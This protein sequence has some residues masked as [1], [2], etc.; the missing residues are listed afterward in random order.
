MWRQPAA[1]QPTAHARGGVSACTTARRRFPFSYAGRA[2]LS[3]YRRRCLSC[4]QHRRHRPPP[5]W[6]SQPRIVLFFVLFLAAGLMVKGGGAVRH[7]IGRHGTGHRARSQHSPP[8]PPSDCAHIDHRRAPHP[9]SVHCK[10]A[11][12]HARERAFEYATA[13]PSPLSHV[14]ASGRTRPSR[15]AGPLLVSCPRCCVAAR[16]SL[17]PLHVTLLRLSAVTLPSHTHPPSAHPIGLLYSLPELPVAR[18]PRGWTRRH[19]P[20]PAPS[21]PSPTVATFNAPSRPWRGP[22]AYGSRLLERLAHHSESAGHKG[23][24]RVRSSSSARI[25][26]RRGKSLFCFFCFVDCSRSYV[27]LPVCSVRVCV[28]L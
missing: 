22:S 5:F 13:F 8:V 17:N 4:C 7:G 15:P 12:R 20:F 11:T 16:G 10:R 21:S 18:R 9:P 23:P 26:L 14:D 28:C 3:F 1:R 2:L 19:S 27:K 6:G 24:A 25:P